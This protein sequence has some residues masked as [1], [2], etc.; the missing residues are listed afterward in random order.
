M[1]PQEN[2]KRFKILILNYEFPPV[3]GGGGVASKDLALEWAKTAQ[4]DVITMNFKGLP[5]AE[6]SEGINIY[7]TQ[8]LMRKSRDVTPFITM[9]TYIITACCKA[10]SLARKNRYDAINTHFAV[11]TGPVGYI[12]SKLFKI[13]NI[14]SLHGG[15]IYDPSKKTSPHTSRF[16]RFVIRFIINA[17]DEVVAQSSNT[18]ENAVKYYGI[19]RHIYI[20]PLP[21]HEPA[22]PKP[23]R[24]SLKLSA[25]DFYF[26]TIGRLVKRKDIDTMLNGLSKIT[27]K[28]AKLLIV[29]DGP[30][31]ERLKNLA[32][33]LGIGGKV[34][35]L[36]H[37]DDE[38]KYRYLTVS[39]CYIM[40]SL[41]EGFGIVF[42]EAMYCSLPVIS[43]NNGGQT[44]FLVNEKNALLINVSDSDGCAAAMSRML[45]DNK[46]YQK[47]SV[48]SRKTVAQF[49]AKKVANEYMEIFGGYSQIQ[50]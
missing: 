49:A 38:D 36:G 26:I 1:K 23:D 46:L 20:I 28:N 29:G 39:N 8:A 31:M 25:K 37:L 41:H 7:R 5:K 4:V 18:R 33:S 15:D 13:P 40:T 45:L 42:M 48:N 16:Y 30:E 32:D 44:D 21:F 24:R 27:D 11:P 17:A 43:T 19:K 3:G 2:P 12:I 22:L 9:L 6:T 34:S 10:I 47:C 35:F 14:L 50:V